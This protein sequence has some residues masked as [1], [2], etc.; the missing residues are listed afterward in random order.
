MYLDWIAATFAL[1]GVYLI[2]KKNKYGF[3]IC[4]ISGI[5]WCIVAV[6]T[7]VYG[8]FLEVLPLFILNMYNFYK[9]KREEIINIL[10]KGKEQ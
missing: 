5:V 2:G 10:R 6:T 9:W 7:A 3:L 8:L 4:M 1:M